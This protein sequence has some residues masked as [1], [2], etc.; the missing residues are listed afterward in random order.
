VRASAAAKTCNAALIKPNQVGTV[1]ATREA[2][3]AAQAAGWDTII[4][5]RSG[6]SEDVT[7]MHLAVGWGA[8]QIK[9]GSMARSERTAKWNEGLRIQDALARVHART[10]RLSTPRWMT[11]PTTQASH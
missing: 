8:T 4:S 5:A 2:F 10:P 9:V 6:E 3:D 11:R 7:I 1:T